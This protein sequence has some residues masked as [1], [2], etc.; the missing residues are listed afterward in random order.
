LST[1]FSA[2][3]ANWAALLGLLAELI[4]AKRMAPAIAS[5]CARGTIPPDDVRVINIA[6]TW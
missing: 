6:Q 5:A 3:A 1:A 4:S 2:A